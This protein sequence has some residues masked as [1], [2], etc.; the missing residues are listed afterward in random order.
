MTPAAIIREAAVDGVCLALS[1]VGTIKVKGEQAAVTRWLPVI[2]EHKSELMAELAVNE[3][4]LEGAIQEAAKERSAILE[5]DGGMHR[6]Q[7]ELVANLYRAFYGHL[8]GIGKATNCCYAPVSRYCPE[9]K[10]LR[11]LYYQACS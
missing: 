2:Q 1:L 5:F 11:D 7:A 6:A 3:E 8:M 4:D 10:R 9:G